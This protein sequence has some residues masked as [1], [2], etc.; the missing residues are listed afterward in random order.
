MIS[1]LNVKATYNGNGLTRAFPI[2]FAF[3]DKSQIYAVLGDGTEID[4]TDFTVDTRAL[5]VTYPKSNDDPALATGETITIYR[6]TDKT[7]QADL[8]NQ[9]GA[10]PETIESSLDKLTQIV[11]EMDE[12]LDRSIK[13]PMYGNESAEEYIE[14]MHNDRLAVDADTAL[15]LQYKNDAAASASKAHNCKDA[16]LLSAATA[17]SAATTAVSNAQAAIDANTAAQAAAQSAGN[18]ASQA[19]T[20]AGGSQHWADLAYQYTELLRHALGNMFEYDEN[21]DI[22]LVEDP[23][24][25]TDPSWELDS[26]NDL[27]PVA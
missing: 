4:Q 21:A 27:Q 11:Q 14:Q 22:Q 13:V 8:T 12:E 17:S 26:N 5:T 23:L 20:S 1:N 16:A 19:A 7:Q 10:W 3:T 2:T 15:V 9:G 25:G 6:V 24:T 18:S